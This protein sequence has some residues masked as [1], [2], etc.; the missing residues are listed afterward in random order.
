MD[1]LEFPRGLMSEKNAERKKSEGEVSE[2]VLHC[3]SEQIGSF[4]FMQ[5]HRNPSSQ[6][7]THSVPLFACERACATA[8]VGMQNALRRI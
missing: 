5:M 2:S 3:Y 4:H 6:S 8:F 7:V 1:T